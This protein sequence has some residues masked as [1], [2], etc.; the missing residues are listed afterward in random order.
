MAE[1]TVI[2]PVDTDP[3][4]GRSPKHAGLVLGRRASLTVSVGVVAHTLWTSAAPALTYRLYAQEWHL[5]YTATTGIFAVFP[6]AVVAMLVAFGG[7]SDRI[8][9]RAAMLAGL[10]A[11]LVGAVLFAVAPDVRWI[12]AGRAFMGIGVGLSAGPST[13]AILE[14]CNHQDAK[15]AASLT[16]AA[17][18]GG[19]AAALL[20]GGALT[21][22]GPWPTRLC[23]WVFAALLAA[24]MIATLFLPRHRFS[25]EK[26]A[27]RPRMPSVPKDTR[28]AFATASTAMMVAYTFGVLVLSLGGQVEHDLIGSSNALLNGSVIALFPIVLGPFGL[29]AK[30]LSSRVALSVGS[31]ASVLGMGLLVLAVSRHDLLLYLIATATAGA[32]YSLLFAGGLRLIDVTGSSRHRG[33]VFSALYLV[34]YVS[35]ATLALV[36]GAVATAWGLRVAIYLGAAAITI[37]SLVALVLAATTRPDGPKIERTK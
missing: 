4:A 5:A 35:M 23:F 20:I 26:G 19:F 2:L 24:L 6:I 28:R 25:S 9:R 16:M 27:W 29:I 33:A 11:S 15:H 31:V 12:F 17:Q 1:G 7:I 22:Y 3:G 36:S 34:G 13:A 30:G 37:V 14:F 21:E 32:S 18:A 8:G 10:G